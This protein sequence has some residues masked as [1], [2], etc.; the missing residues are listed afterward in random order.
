MAQRIL[1]VEDETGIAEAVAFILEKEGF[2]T[3]RCSSAGD[4]GEALR[5]AGYDLVILDIGL[6]DMNGFDFCRELLRD[7]S[8]PVIFLTARSDEIDRIVGLEMGADDYVTKPFSPRELAARVKAVLRRTRSSAPDDGGESEKL[9]CGAFLLD[10]ERKQLRYFG[11]PLKLSRYE[12]QILVL[13]LRHPG[14]IYSRRQLLEAIW[15]EPEACMERTVDTHIKTI[16]A[17]LKAIN[18]QIEAIETSRGFGWALAE[19]AVR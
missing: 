10:E 9:T 5:S 15:E 19:Q 18:G 3:R 16:R 4:A 12:Y 11:E 6:P 17:K 2:E 8:L 14:R 1:I 7:Y 13:M